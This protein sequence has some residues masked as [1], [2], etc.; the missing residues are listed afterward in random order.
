[1][2]VRRLTA[3]AWGAGS[4]GTIAYLNFVTALILLYLTV[5]VQLEPFVA[6][7]LV[8]AARVVDAFLDPLMG[9]LTDRTQTRLGRR[10]P[11]L[12][13]GAL[14]CGAALPLVYSVHSMSTPATAAAIAF[15]ALVVYSIGFTVFNVPY[16]AMPVEMTEDRGERLSIMS[17]R[18]TFMMLG[19]LLGNA[20]GPALVDLLGGDGR[21]YQ[22]TGIIIGAVVA[23][24]MLAAFAGT[25]SANASRRTETNTRYAEH[26]SAML[27]N[28]PFMTLIGFKVLQFIAIAAVSSTL[29]FYVTVVLK[30]DFRLLSVF[31]VVVTLS[32]VVAVPVWRRLGDS[33]TKRRGVVIGVVGEMVS[34]LVWLVAT[35]DTA[36]TAVVVRAVLAGVFGSA[37][38]LNSQ[39]MWLDTIDYDRQRSG[40][41]REGVY[42]SIYVFVERLG[43]SVGPLALG[44]LLSLLHFDKTQP[45]DQQ[46]ASAELAVYIGIV[47]L[48]LAMY[49][50]AVLL[51]SRYTLEDSVP[52]RTATNEGA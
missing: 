38:L 23:M 35:P 22:L 48:P 51:L 49:G 19:G 2:A 52:G 7:A 44:A 13:V 25:A 50:M 33:M 36:Y 31:G 17:Y 46:P 27:Q 21:A 30:Q 18:V 41:S 14:V 39:A 34:S 15:V 43:Y 45:L 28:R 20:G 5:E 9:W 6:G 29:A 12:F 16:L 37:I 40:I 11:Y 26:L 10:R 8:A 42:T 4:F 1:M 32:I 3:I 24:F 47:W